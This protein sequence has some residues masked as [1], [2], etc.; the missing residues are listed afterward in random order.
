MRLNDLFYIDYHFLLF[1]ALDIDNPFTEQNNS[2]EEA[3]AYSIFID[4]R[5]EA[6]IGF[7]IR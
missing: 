2:A 7:I 6:V 5:Y 4:A 3:S 1:T